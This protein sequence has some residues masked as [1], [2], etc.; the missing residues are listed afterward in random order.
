MTIMKKLNDTVIIVLTI[1]STIVGYL[2]WG[3]M[4]LIVLL[5]PH[6]D[7]TISF[8]FGGVESYIDNIIVQRHNEQFDGG[9][10]SLS[11]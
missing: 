11:F 10:L 2:T 8:S 6:I 1:A 5:I 9:R 7:N 3:L 4:A